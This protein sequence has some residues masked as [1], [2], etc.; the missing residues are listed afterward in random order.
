M[1]LRHVFYPYLLSASLVLSSVSAVSATEIAALDT[2]A[3]PPPAPAASSPP[4]SS[5]A[6]L[7]SRHARRQGDEGKAIEVLKSIQQ[8]DPANST[9]RQQLLILYL[10][11]GRMEQAIA[12]A[13]ALRDAPSRELI[14][15]LLLTVD[16]T[17]QGQFSQ[18]LST[19]NH[20]YQTSSGALWVPLIKAWLNI[21]EGT[22]KSPLYPA[23]ILPEDET[24]QTPPSFV[25]YLL[26]LI[27]DRAGFKDVAASHYSSAL[28]QGNTTPFRAVQAAMNFFS[29]QGDAQEVK[30]IRQHYAATHPAVAELID[31]TT[32]PDRLINTVQEGVAEVFFTMASV[33]YGVEATADAQLYLRMALYLKPDFPVAQLMLGNLLEQEN[34][35]ANAAATYQA[36]NPASPLA[37]RALL[38]QAY[39]IEQQ[40]KLEEAIAMLDATAAAAPQD[41][42]ASI[43]KGD[44]LR[45]RGLFESATEAY[46]Q[47]ISRIPQLDNRH[48]GLL[49]ARGASYERLG[50]W[51]RAEA[52]LRKALKLEPDQPEVLNYLG[53]GLLAREISLDEARELIEHAYALNPTAPH[54]VDSLGW[55]LYKTGDIEG[56]V[57]YLEQAVEMMPSDATVNDHL[58]DAYWRAGRRTEARYQWERALDYQPDQLL[59]HTLRQKLESGLTPLDAPLSAQPAEMLRR[60]S[61]ANGAAAP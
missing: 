8:R 16:E 10:N 39:A 9:L 55:A 43:A 37:R 30:A 52:D 38:R 46:S 18:A 32:R 28:E 34:E 35:Y 6:F 11:E 26:A 12:E 1:P 21:G 17:S 61:P 40:G 27:N 49:F 58:G 59:E 57:K 60:T 31:E 5:G 50:E 29:R 3:P 22:L 4:I 15:D 33:L 47:A 25:F 42:A 44:L 19:L 2:P 51:D 45:Q 48:W 54:I 36:I 41:Y 14:V 53:Y 24:E 7:T 20:V 13:R 23:A 56:A